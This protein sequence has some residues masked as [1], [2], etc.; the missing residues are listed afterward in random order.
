M[1]PGH[2]GKFR[3]RTKTRGEEHGTFL[4]SGDLTVA[5]MMDYND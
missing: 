4:R 2:A 5:T 1:V 3:L